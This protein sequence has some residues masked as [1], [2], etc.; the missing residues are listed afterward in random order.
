MCFAL[1]IGLCFV[2]RFLL[3]LFL[4]YLLERRVYVS[5]WFSSLIV[6]LLIYYKLHVYIIKSLI[7]GNEI[8]N[9]SISLFETIGNL[10]GTSFIQL[11]TPRF[12][13]FSDRSCQILNIVFQYGYCSDV[14]F[15]AN[16]PL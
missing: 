1:E 13:I 9:I 7:R 15:L 4:I 6:L 8:L 14:P 5:C 2:L 10:D 12:S 3:E 11:L 16:L